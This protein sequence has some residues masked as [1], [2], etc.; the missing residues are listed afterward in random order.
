V[1]GPALKETFYELKRISTEPPSDDEMEHARRYL[2][3]NTALD[4]QSRTEVAVRL[5]NY[6]IDG[7]PANHLD[8]QMAAI[9]KTTAAEAAQAAAKY[10]NPEH[11]MI[12]AVGEKQVILDQLKAFG[13]E[14]T[15]AP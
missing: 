3:G 14:V 13:M 7:E 8:E 11:M 5:G 15:P 6:W 9:Q 10:F 12:V 1:T 4:L 2:I